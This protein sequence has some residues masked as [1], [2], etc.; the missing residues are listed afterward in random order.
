MN[1]CL[2]LL[3]KVR[4]IIFAEQQ[5]GLRLKRNVKDKLLFIRGIERILF[6]LE[7]F[8]LKGFL[9]LNKITRACVNY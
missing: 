6:V 2:V 9:S 4:S 8:K 7:F 1:K 5:Q 3:L